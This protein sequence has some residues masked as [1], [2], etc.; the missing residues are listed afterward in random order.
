MRPAASYTTP[1]DTIAGCA[2]AVGGD[3]DKRLGGKIGPLRKEHGRA[4]SRLNERR[5]FPMRGVGRVAAGSRHEWSKAF[6]HAS[7]ACMS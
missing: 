2:L 3:P 1:W 5:V 6:V 7:L 4:R